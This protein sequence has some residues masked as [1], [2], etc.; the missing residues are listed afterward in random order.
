M[1]VVLLFFNAVQNYINFR[2]IFACYVTNYRYVKN[3]K[4]ELKVGSV[5]TITLILKMNSTRSTKL[6]LENERR[7]I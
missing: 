3:I 5:L 6:L 1:R 2:K 7:Y 4:L